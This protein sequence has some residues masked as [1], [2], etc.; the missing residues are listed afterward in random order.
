MQFTL[1]STPLTGTAL[2]D[3]VALGCA[4][5]VRKRTDSKEI[6]GVALSVSATDTLDKRQQRSGPQSSSSQKT[7][8]QNCHMVAKKF[9]GQSP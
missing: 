3:M 1:R 4:A 5:E 6:R 2:E 7:R 9:S 8:A